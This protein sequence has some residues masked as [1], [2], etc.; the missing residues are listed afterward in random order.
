M[1]F[2]SIS[3]RNEETFESLFG[4]TQA[5][6]H[7]NIKMNINLVNAHRLRALQWKGKPIFFSGTFHLLRFLYT[8]ALGLVAGSVLVQKAIDRQDAFFAFMISHGP[9]K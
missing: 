2:V 1:R 5:R 4:P 3:S 6:E 7:E 8:A 9:K